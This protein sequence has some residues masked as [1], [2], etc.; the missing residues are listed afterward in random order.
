MYVFNSLL[1]LLFKL[2]FYQFLL[3]SLYSTVLSL[4]THSA[5]L[6]GQGCHL[7]LMTPRVT[8][9]TQ[10]IGISGDQSGELQQTTYMPYPTTFLPS[11]VHGQFYILS[12]DL[13]DKDL[14]RT[15]FMHMKS[16]IK[17]STNK[18]NFEQPLNPT[19]M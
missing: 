13:L 7:I 6:P 4:P 16:P 2:Q 14:I 8:A 12:V 15:D 10:S 17:Q 3:Y 9:H 1:N 11:D 18:S 5:P 19:P